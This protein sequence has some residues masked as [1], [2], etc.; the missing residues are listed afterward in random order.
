MTQIV[1]KAKLLTLHIRYASS[2]LSL[3]LSAKK[4]ASYE[5]FLHYLG[6]NY[7]IPPIPPMPPIPPGIAGSSFGNSATAAS[8]VKNIAATEAAF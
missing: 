1:D 6:R 3:L 7:I 8:V 5:T 4:K 2:A